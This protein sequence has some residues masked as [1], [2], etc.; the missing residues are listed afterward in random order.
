M[1][2]LKQCKT[3]EFNF[4][5]TC[6]GHGDTYKYGEKITD[7]ALGCDDWGADLDYF[8]ELTTNAP[9]YVKELYNDLKVD[10]S[11]FLELIE[12][13]TAGQPIEVNIYDA[14]R[15]GSEYSLV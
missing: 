10:Y 14:I 6:A 8:I 5:G 4:S 12:A 11:R 3:C 15:K 7:D 13:D 1:K 2:L 9:W